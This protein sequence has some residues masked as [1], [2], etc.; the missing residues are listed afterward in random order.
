MAD[1][2]TDFYF[3]DPLRSNLTNLR[4]LGSH[5]NGIPLHDRLWATQAMSRSEEV[6]RSRY[7]I[8]IIIIIVN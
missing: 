4:D 2:G 1:L 6:N 7:I 5:F 8:I 3:Y